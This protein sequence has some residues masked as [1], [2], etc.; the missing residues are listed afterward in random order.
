[1]LISVNH[2]PV[3]W[4]IEIQ[5]HSTV[6]AILQNKRRTDVTALCPPSNW[7]VNFFHYYWMFRMGKTCANALIGKQMEKIFH[8]PSNTHLQ[9][10]KYL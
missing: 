9:K 8:P 6:E 2:R 5:F 10:L 7:G 1:M 3:E 4:W